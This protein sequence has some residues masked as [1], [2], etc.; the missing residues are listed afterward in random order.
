MKFWNEYKKKCAEDYINSIKTKDKS[1]EEKSKYMI[2]IT[3]E[4]LDDLI[5]PPEIIPFSRT[6][7]VSSK[8]EAIDLGK[9]EYEKGNKVEIWKLIS[10]WK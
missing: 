10:R 4:H 3:G 9:L 2:E 1:K 6:E 5:D 7:Y 8:D